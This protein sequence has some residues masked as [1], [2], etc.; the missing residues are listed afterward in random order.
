MF[1][2]IRY[3]VDAKGV[4]RLTLAQPQ[5]HNALSAIMIGELTEAAE[6]LSVDV[7]VRVVVLDA[8]GRSFCAGGDLNW[9]R[10]Q[11]DADRPTRIAEAT[12]LPL[13]TVKS[14]VL[15]G[16]EKLKRIYA[17]VKS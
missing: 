1:E 2:T 15:R 3:A 16:S 9:M 11:F 7:T 8:E 14:H 10:E 4:A 17:G 13:G 5:K 6:R 12:R